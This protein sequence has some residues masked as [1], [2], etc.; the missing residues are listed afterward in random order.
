MELRLADANLILSKTPA[1]LDLLLRDLPEEWLRANEGKDT[2]SCYDVVGHL[3]HGELTDWMPRLQI[4][5][6]HGGDR[7]F[8]PFDRFAQFENDQTRPIGELLDR[9]KSLRQ[10]NLQRLNELHLTPGDWGRPGE[11]PELGTVTL[12]ELISTWVVHDLTH[13]NQIH[14]VMATQYS[15][16]VGPWKQYL[17]ILTR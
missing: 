17:S 15:E 13:L 10:Q 3:I 16:A 2:W 1:C 8:V 11:H 12:S 4:I 7:A 9:F 6:E 5:L 14:R